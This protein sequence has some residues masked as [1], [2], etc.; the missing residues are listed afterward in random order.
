MRHLLPPAVVLA[1]IL[2]A[3][4]ARAQETTS[5][6]EAQLLAILSEETAI[7]T[8]TR[9]NSDFVPGIVTV[10]HG[11]ELEA[12]GVETAWEAL[13]LVPGMMAVRDNPGLP[14]VF[15]RGLD[16]PFNSGN[17]KVLVNSIPLS[18]ESAGINGIALFIPVQL[19]DRIEV[20][21]GPGSV[22]YGDFAFMGLVN[23]VT[24]QEGQ[25]AYLR[26][27]GDK[28]FSGGVALNFQDPKEGWNASVLA[29]GFLNNTAAVNSP[30]EAKEKRGF[31]AVS[32]Q[33]GG[34]S[35]TAE[36]V[37]R[38]VDDQSVEPGQPLTGG[39]GHW[40]VEGRYGR[41]LTPSF[42]AEIRA[43]FLHN[44]FDTQISD[45]KGD[46]ISTG[47][48]AK[49][50]GWRDHALLFSVDY[51]GSRISEAGFSYAVMPGQ[52]PLT[53]A[54]FAQNRDA[55][56]LTL[57]DTFDVSPKLAITAGARFDR[58]SDIGSRVTPRLAVV[59]RVT[60]EHIVKAQYAEGFRAP[61]FFE[62]YGSGRRDPDL[63]FEV[64][65]TVEASYAFRRPDTAARATIFF[66]RIHDMIF[67]VMGLGRF[68]NGHKAQAWG[69]E[70]EAERQI[71]ERVKVTAQYSW[72]DSED[73]RNFPRVTQTPPSRAPS[74]AGASVL[75]RALSRT[76]VGARWS[77]VG[78]R[79]VPNGDGFNLVDLTVT[80]N[81]LFVPG[82]QLRAGV[83]NVL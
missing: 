79:N 70:L 34:F 55:F 30:R 17:V 3:G 83:K 54:L 44:R 73:N 60:D 68:D 29:S 48:D 5:S 41:D 71:G 81:E 75:V 49:W 12:L 26:E 21:R 20:I 6:E 8:K 1:A 15:V 82:L 66:S 9:M 14:S 33:K 7:A 24:R 22:L 2:A 18:R 28:A 72:V 27:G 61:T 77:L 67:P 59:W 56:G 13:S 42:H 31:G 80:Q 52:P 16:F 78:R 65:Q 64:N 39:Q 35:F 47:V 62:E 4:S 69:V 36:G 43:S 74:L 25:R 40:A 46:V 57:Q 32:I 51:T 50:T 37:S 38:R 76:L 53:L 63:D 11:D 58:Y 10:L 45:F 23:I 19:I